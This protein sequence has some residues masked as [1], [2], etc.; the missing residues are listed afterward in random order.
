MLKTRVLL[1]A[2]IALLWA[3]A[4]AGVMRRSSAEA[5]SAATL[6]SVISLS[7][8]AV[9]AA[10]VPK[11]HPAGKWPLEAV[12][13]PTHGAATKCREV[14]PQLMETRAEM[15]VLPPVAEAP[16]VVE[17]RP[18]PGKMDK[19]RSAGRAVSDASAQSLANS[20]FMAL[21]E[22]VETTRR[23]AG[24][25]PDE[26]ATVQAMVPYTG[27]V[28]TQRLAAAAAAVAEV[29]ELWGAAE[30][31]ESLSSGSVPL[32]LAGLAL[33]LLK[34][35]AIGRSCSDLLVGW[36]S[37]SCRSSERT[38]AQSELR[39]ISTSSVEKYSGRR[40]SLVSAF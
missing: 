40:R 10:G 36:K 37:S 21:A 6:P 35:Q 19:E 12:G 20:S 28:A 33:K 8:S 16:A 7:R 31:T 27:M 34:V 5:R 24:P 9:V 13:T 14:G 39:R 22:A 25:V 11:R 32:K 18:N 1:R 29:T 15:R 38:T 17:A 23:Q 30:V 4:V 3:L 2:G 26:V